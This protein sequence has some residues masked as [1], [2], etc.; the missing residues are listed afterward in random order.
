MNINKIT[1]VIPVKKNSSRLPGK[2]ILPFGDSTL[3]EHKISQLKKV[4][5]ISKIIVSSDS[6]E[7]LDKALSMGVEAIKRPLNLADESRPLSEFFDYICT[8]IN[9]G[10]LMWACCTSPLFGVTLFKKAVSLYFEKID[11][12]FDSLI[13]VTPFKHYL[14][15]ERKPLNYSIG[16]DHV[17]SQ[18]L[19]KLY[20]FTNGVILAP[21]RNVKEWR[22]NY[23]PNPFRML[24]NQ[25]QSIDI[26]TYHDYLAACAWYDDINKL[27]EEEGIR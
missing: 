12:G 9:E 14:M 11:E 24:V 15:D 18:Y 13:T 10:H 17:N 19:P 25:G 6:E 16:Q 2:N 20:V 22:Y 5:G 7:M 8:L 23:G 4:Q 21:I 27:D 26:D 1:A 3:L